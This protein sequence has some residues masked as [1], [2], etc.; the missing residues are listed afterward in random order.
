VWNLAF[1]YF[2]VYIVRQGLTYVVGGV[3]L[4]I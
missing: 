1:A 3:D 2:C 4:G